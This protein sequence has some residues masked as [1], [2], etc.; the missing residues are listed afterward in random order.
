MEYWNVDVDVSKYEF[1]VVE[2][3]SGEG[4]VGEVVNYV[5]D[6]DFIKMDE[7][8]NDVIGYV[9]LDWDKYWVR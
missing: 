1:D 2:Y 7:V 3:K 9:V 4:G 8:D 6:K 5:D